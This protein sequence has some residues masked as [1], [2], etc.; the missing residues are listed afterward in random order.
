[1]RNGFTART[2]CRIQV[3]FSHSTTKMRVALWTSMEP[4][5]HRTFVSSLI[6]LITPTRR[7]LRRPEEYR[8]RT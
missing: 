2:R 7:I 5:V 3:A 6:R 8:R 4:T 1:M